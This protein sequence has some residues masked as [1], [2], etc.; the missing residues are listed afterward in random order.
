MARIGVVGLRRG[1]E[2]A[3]W[4]ARLGLEVA[5]LCE[6]DAE[7]LASAA[8]EFP[9]AWTARDW[10]ELLDRP[11]DG[12]VLAHDFD[13][14]AEPSVAFLERG[15]HVLAECAACGTEEEGRA[16]VEAAERGPARYSFAENYVLHP[17][18]RL[19]AESLGGGEIGEVTLI[20][21]DY[22]HGLSPEREAALVG[23]PG[24]W[25][26]RIGPTAYCTH[27]LSP[28]LDL[29]GAWPVEVT[30]HPVLP[31]PRPGATVLVVRLSS[32]ALAVTRQTFL[33]GEPDSHW[34][35]VSV[36]GTRGLAESA[37]APGDEAWVVR[38]RRE[39]WANGGT[40][41]DVRRDPPRLR[42]GGRLVERAE[43]G[44]ALVVEAFR[45][46]LLE[47]AP[48]RVGVRQAVA[49]SLVGVAGGRSLE[50]GSVPVPVPDVAAWTAG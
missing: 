17:H 24:H 5:A 48:P 21:A 42:R 10:P 41:R 45:D 19:L 14:H 28:V 1:R 15:V 30:A 2:L 16:L 44:T 33:Q 3:R 9:G 26:G 36:R 22:L 23:D 50:R 47:G 37:R 12:V 27:T 31:G 11:L 20:E 8:A 18:V 39:P 4:C 29:T 13:A 32:G 43:E 38:V 25:R 49:A 34:S 7:V 35:W 6:R 46:T 40:V